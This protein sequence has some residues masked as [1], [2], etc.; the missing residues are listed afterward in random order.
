MESSTPVASSGVSFHPIDT[1]RSKSIRL[2]NEGFLRQAQICSRTSTIARIE[3]I[4]SRVGDD[5]LVSRTVPLLHC[6]RRHASIEELVIQHKKR[7]SCTTQRTAAQSSRSETPRKAKLSDARQVG[8]P[9]SSSSAE[10]TLY[11]SR[12]RR[13]LKR[14]ASSDRVPR[15]QREIPKTLSSSRISDSLTLFRLFYFRRGVASSSS[16]EEPDRIVASRVETSPQLG[17]GAANRAGPEAF[18]RVSSIFLSLW[19]SSA[20]KGRLVTALS[21]CLSS[22]LSFKSAFIPVWRPRKLACRFLAQLACLP[23]CLPACTP[24]HPPAC[25]LGRCSSSRRGGRDEKTT[26][27]TGNGSTGSTEQKLH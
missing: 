4:R 13:G 14:S 17:Y 12:T 7:T 22:L 9:P 27:P 23:A 19:P 10:G 1:R 26:Q 11:S 20:N 21:Q 16:S 2:M 24:V 18:N 5:S 8:H 6:C 15:E 3:P 25:L